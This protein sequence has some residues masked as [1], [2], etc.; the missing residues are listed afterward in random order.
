[1][2]GNQAVS[3]MSKRKLQETRPKKSVRMSMSPEEVILIRRRRLANQEDVSSFLLQLTVLIVLMYFLFTCVFGITPMR[4]DDMKPKI[5]SGDL[6]LYYRLEN[7]WHAEDVVVFEKNGEQYVGRIIA[8]GGDKVEVTEEARVVV[9]DSYIAENDI[10][11]STPQYESDVT[12]PIQLEEDQF[13]VLCDYRQGA[14]DSRYFGAVDL[15]EVKGKVITVIRRS[16]L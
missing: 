10:Y 11:Y 9:N 5:G 4:N 2:Q 3:R 15:S 7:K 16:G 1:M 13:F 14:K 6:L 12:Y 8:R